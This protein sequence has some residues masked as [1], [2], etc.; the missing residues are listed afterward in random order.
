MDKIIKEFREKFVFTYPFNGKIKQDFNETTPK[1]VET[2]I[3]KAL[4]ARDKEHFFELEE[5]RMK[6]G[7][8]RRN[9]HNIYDKKLKAR[10]KEIISWIKDWEAEGK[11]CYDDTGNK[12]VVIRVKKAV[13]KK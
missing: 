6:E 1:D 3:L 2:F 4:K 11:P 7:E 9:Q 8:I 12:L 5:I 13:V 10:D